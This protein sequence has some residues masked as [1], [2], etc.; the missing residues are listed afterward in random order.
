ML[1]LM[2]SLLGITLVVAAAARLTPRRAY[3]TNLGVMS[4][5]WIAEHR[6]TH[7]S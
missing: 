2:G 5:P 4:E 7:S 3:A 6:A 1:L